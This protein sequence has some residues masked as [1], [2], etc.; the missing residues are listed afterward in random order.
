MKKIDISKKIKDPHTNKFFIRGKEYINPIDGK[1]G[2]FDSYITTSVYKEGKYKGFYYLWFK[3]VNEWFAKEE[4]RKTRIEKIRENIKNGKLR[5]IKQKNPETGKH[6]KPGDIKFINNIEYVFLCY[7]D[8]PEGK[9]KDYE[10][11][12]KQREKWVTKDQLVRRRVSRILA[13][14]KYRAKI[15]KIPYDIDLKY[16]MSIYPKNNM[17]P[18]LQKQFSFGYDLGEG[19]RGSQNHYSPS[20]DKIIP[21]KGYVRNNVV[22]VSRLANVIKS[23]ASIET[24]EL[25]GNFFLKLENEKTD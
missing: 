9:I 1:K 21:Q 19:G 10:G 20:L 8:F 6:F 3:S 4:K 23:D 2:V 11:R 7:D 18:A 5:L 15:K 22:W 24:L 25:I 16:V 14:I 12:Y 17:C 13:K